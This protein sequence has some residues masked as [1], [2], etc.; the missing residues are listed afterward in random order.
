MENGTEDQDKKTD[1]AEDRTDWAEDRTV[2]ANERTF[3]GWMRT[4]MA[5]V[6]LALGLRAVFRQA[7][8]D[9]LPRAVALVFIAIAIGIFWAARSQ[10][11]KAQRRLDTHDANA[12]PP[13]IFTV[14]SI[15][16][17]FAAVAVGYVLWTL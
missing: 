13:K 15:V 12:Q 14:L 6:A 5:A 17:S 3:A 8:P 4:G 7:E 16:F 10:A 11:C 9:W 2:L 1:W